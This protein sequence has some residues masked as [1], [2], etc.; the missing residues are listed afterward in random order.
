MIHFSCM[1]CGKKLHAKD[2]LGGRTA[3]C[4][5]CG[6][7][8]RIP[9]AGE[10]PDTMPLD[11]ARPGETIIPVSEEHLAGFEAPKRL[12]RTSHYVICDR[13]HLLAAWQNDGAGWMIRVGTGFQPAKRNRDKLPTG[14]AYQLTELKF[15][16]TPEGKRL[17]GIHSFQ[18]ASRWAL[19]AL[20]QSD[21]AI[22]EKIGAAGCLNKDQKN[23]IRQAIKDQF[24][25]PVW[26][27]AAAVLEYLG[28]GDYHSHGVE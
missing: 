26:E 27:G 10:I 13:M 14:G 20:D 6:K 28:N 9:E 24:M 7:P 19:T 18:L 12:D 21:D 17:A 3:K 2:E 23:A 5:N 11:D 8:F 16:M 25:R 22:L 1:S 4:P 15:A